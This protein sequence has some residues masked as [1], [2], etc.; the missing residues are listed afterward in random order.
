MQ[1]SYRITVFTLLVVPVFAA[2]LPISG[3]MAEDAPVYELRVYTCEPGKLQALNER[4]QNHTMKIFARHGMENVAYW[5]PTEGPKSTTTL[6]YLLRH[7]SRDAA[8]NSWSGF[9]QD[10]EWRQVAAA[11]REKHG[12][13]LAKS[14][15]ATYM[16][17]TDYSPE[18][19]LAKPDR[20]YELRI[21]TAGDGK[22]EALH[23]RFRRHTD[24]LFTKHGMKAIGYW[25][26]SDEP[27]SNNEMIYVLEHKDRDSANASWKAF[28]GDPDWQAAYRKSTASGRLLAKSPERVYMKATNY[29]PTK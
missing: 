15:E 14:P 25:K 7:K 22:L 5:I 2:S 13:I 11:S 10:P 21:Y 8:K 17:A 16:T 26:P 20:L 4:F 27:Q 9:R 3:A 24:D 19:G 23:D 1:L 28:V 29:S 18:T 12:K 6:I